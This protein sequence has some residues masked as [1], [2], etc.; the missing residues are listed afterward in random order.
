MDQE[1]YE[2]AEWQEEFR[3]R[4]AQCPKG[5][6]HRVA[7]RVGL[8][9]DRRSRLADTLGAEMIVISWSQNLDEGRAA[10]VRSLIGAAPCPILLVTAPS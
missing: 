5:G 9:D 8:L 6:R 2:W 3:M 1:H 4:F 7:V 10:H